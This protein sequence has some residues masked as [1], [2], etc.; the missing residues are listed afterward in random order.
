MDEDQKLTALK[1]KGFRADM[2]SFIDFLKSYG[3]DSE[4]VKDAIKCLKMAKMWMGVYMGTLP[5]GGE[6]LNA[7]RDAEEIAKAYPSAPENPSDP[8]PT[9][10][11]TPDEGQDQ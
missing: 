11:S 8:A 10:A 3:I 5:D 1:V 7:K 6:D 4:E 2:Q 9:G